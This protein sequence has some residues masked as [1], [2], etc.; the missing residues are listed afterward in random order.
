MLEDRARDAFLAAVTI[1][2]ANAASIEDLKETLR[3]H[4][5]LGATRFRFGILEATPGA[6]EAA[7]I[8]AKTVRV[9]HT[10]GGGK[11]LADADHRFNRFGKHGSR[12][13]HST[14]AD[15]SNLPPQP[16]PITS[17][18]LFYYIFEPDDDETE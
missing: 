16:S 12:S 5:N 17:V 18:V 3:K 10:D 4:Y 13:T 7:R 15:R 1:E 14:V 8:G 9:N 11:G 6:L 2:G